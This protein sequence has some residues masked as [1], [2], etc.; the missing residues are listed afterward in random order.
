MNNKEDPIQYP[1]STKENK[2]ISIIGGPESDYNQ[3]KN[4]N[5]N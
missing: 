2:K 3:I 1:R 4:E 5:N